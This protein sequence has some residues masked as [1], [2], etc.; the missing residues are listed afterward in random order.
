MDS[1]WIDG[2]NFRTLKQA[3]LLLTGWAES[4]P[5]WR[6]VGSAK[7]GT[8]EFSV[9][10]EGARVA[11]GSAQLTF[12]ARRG[13]TPQPPTSPQA[14]LAFA[15]AYPGSVTYPR[16]PDFTGT[17][18]L[19]Q[20]PIALTDQPAALRQPPQTATFAAVTAPL[21]RY[22]DAL[23]PALWRAA[24]ISRRRRHGWIP[25]STMAPSA[26]HSRL[27]RCT[28]GNKPPAANYRRTA[29]ASALPRGPSATSISLPSRL[30]PGAVA[31]AKSG[32]QFPALA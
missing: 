30:T 9:A 4:L 15:R 11:V 5:N 21:W 1:P 20:L 19:E 32:G 12:I 8:E 25:C 29:T 2:E 13:Q 10:T 28:P 26:Y 7:A 16:P 3:N 23:H 17:A 24:R 18:L 27:T 14:L 31:G 22:L 6:Y